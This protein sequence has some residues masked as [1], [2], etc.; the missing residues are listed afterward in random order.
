[1]RKDKLKAGRLALLLLLLVLIIGICG[2]IF[3]EGFSFTEA[4]FMTIITIATV[5]FNEVKPLSHAGMYFTSFLIIFSIGI[6][7]YA[8]STLTRYIVEGVFRNYYRDN[9]VKSKISTL[10]K[11]VVICGYGRNGKQAALELKAS[12][13][14]HVIIE[15]E[16]QAIEQ[17][18]MATGE[19]FVHGDAT[20]DEVLRTA[21]IEE[22]SALIT[23][24]PFD[25][26]NLFVVLTARQVNPKLVIISRAS[27]DHSDTKLKLA[28]A[29]NVIMPDKIGGQRMA[30]LVLQPDVVEFLEYLMLQGTESVA[31]EEITLESLSEQFSGKPIRKLLAKNDSGANIVGMR[32]ADKTFVINPLPETILDSN[33]KLFVLGTKRQIQNIRKTIAEV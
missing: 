18:R 23:T 33:D 31:I 16:D 1:M 5:G 10:S 3:I 7:A 28:G 19:L 21:N 30:K 6:F 14:P 20:Q 22:A 25:A 29:N 17:L 26:D 8:V 11:H 9:K 24:L 4:F 13:I 15:K 2:Y 27:A 12:R 32:R